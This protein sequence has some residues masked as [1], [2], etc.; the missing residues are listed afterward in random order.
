MFE[1]PEFLRFSSARSL[2]VWNNSQAGQLKRVKYLASPI[3]NK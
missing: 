3:D 2:G 1:D